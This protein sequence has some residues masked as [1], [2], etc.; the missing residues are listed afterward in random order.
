MQH[1]WASIHVCMHAKHSTHHV[2]KV[3]QSKNKSE[4]L[5]RI[6][7]YFHRGEISAYMY[8]NFHTVTIICTKELHL[9]TTEN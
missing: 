9:R 5:Y 7:G 1:K 2:S 3:S 6:M 4:I 8:E